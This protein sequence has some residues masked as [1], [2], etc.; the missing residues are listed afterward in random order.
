MCLGFW[1]SENFWI[2]FTIGEFP[3]TCRHKN[4]EK[5]PAKSNEKYIKRKLKICRLREKSKIR[6]SMNSLIG[7]FSMYFYEEF[8]NQFSPKQCES[9][10]IVCNFVNKLRLKKRLCFQKRAQE[11]TSTQH[12][13]HL[14]QCGPN[15]MSNDMLTKLK[16]CKFFY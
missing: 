13:A 2:L 8:E 6:F 3:M 5:Y 15:W 12:E 4:N 14:K 10:K 9:R 7:N 11:E 16:R 1:C